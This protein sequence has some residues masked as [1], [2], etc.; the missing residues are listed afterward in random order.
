MSTQYSQVQNGPNWYTNPDQSMRWIPIKN[1]TS[2]TIPAFA[3]FATQ[4]FNGD[5]GGGWTYEK[6]NGQLYMRVF[7]PS[8]YHEQVQLPAFH[9]FNGPS[10]IPPGKFGVGT[11]DFPCRALFDGKTYQ[12][13]TVSLLGPKKDS[14]YLRTGGTCFV[15]NDLDPSYPIL[16]DYSG[17]RKSESIHAMWIFDARYQL[18]EHS[19]VAALETLSPATVSLPNVDGYAESQPLEWSVPLIGQD[20]HTGIGEL[21]NAIGTGLVA[22]NSAVSLAPTFRYITDATAIE[23]LSPRIV[24]GTFTARVRGSTQAGLVGARL[25][26]ERDGTDIQTPYYM[27][28]SVQQEIDQYGNVAA[29]GLEATLSFPIQCHCLEGD[30][31]RVRNFVDKTQYLNAYLQLEA[32]N[33]RFI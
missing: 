12:A 25:Y 23:V 28:A 26:V 24:K 29:R 22:F 15:S 10:P 33:Y 6:K 17:S 5:A 21:G 4:A 7:K 13:T 9:G 20:G 14:W 8:E 31:I 18:P 1:M 19:V 2:E 32:S 30:I 27:T 11:R 16:K 3:C